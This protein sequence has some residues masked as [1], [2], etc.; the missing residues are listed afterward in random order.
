MTSLETEDSLRSLE[1]LWLDAARSASRALIELKK[2]ENA[3]TPALLDE[4][5][6]RFGAA[7][8]QKQ[9]IMHEIESIEDAL[10]A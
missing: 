1:A 7:Q 8:A 3:E 6:E 5:L 10:I 9:Q 2:H 4:A